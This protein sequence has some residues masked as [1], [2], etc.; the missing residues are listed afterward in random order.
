MSFDKSSWLEA[1][2]REGAAFRTAVTAGDLEKP[3]PSCPG[4]NV[5][6]LVAHLGQTY[7][8]HRSH[9]VRGVTS[10]PE[11][12]REPAP[13][14]AAVLPWWDEA[15]A[16][17]VAT[18]EQLDPAAPAWNWSVKPQQAAFWHRRMA[19]ETAVH[20]WDMQTALGLP[21]PID[22][23]EL[24]ADG[25]DEVLDSF[26][27]SKPPQQ[28]MEITGVARLVATDVEATWNVRVRSNGV[29]LLDTG[30]WFDSEPQVATIAE[31]S[32]SDLLLTVWGRVPVS[33]L[34]VQGEPKLV[35]ELQVTG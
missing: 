1:L 18:L 31:G 34:A 28:P 8:F 23:P 4:W 9:L 25:I 22:P 19:H 7:S 13:V 14:G 21:E 17:L 30:G 26:L 5:H 6:A 27:P 20:R 12:E 32:A 29:S 10:R 2:R 33:V 3:V 15:F 24:A 11:K 35:E 16:Q